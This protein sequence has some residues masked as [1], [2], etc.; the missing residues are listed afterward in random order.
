MTKAVLAKLYSH[1]DCLLLYFIFI[2]WTVYCSNKNSVSLNRI[3]IR[4][5][6]RAVNYANR[7]STLQYFTFP[8]STIQ[9]L[10]LDLRKQEKGGADSHG[11][12]ELQP[13]SENQQRNVDKRLLDKH[14]ALECP[15]HVGLLVSAKV[16]SDDYLW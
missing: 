5:Q 13:L 12:H 3:N 15:W 6:V 7:G 10:I 2:N 9:G 16:N 1:C 4:S 11:R 14:T 8:L